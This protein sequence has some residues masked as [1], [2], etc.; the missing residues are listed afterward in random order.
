MKAVSS[1]IEDDYQR[2]K[3]ETVEDS[4]GRKA[5][6]K[7]RMKSRTRKDLVSSVEAAGY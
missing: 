1:V 4:T 2:S 5:Q 6:P 3:L 7:I